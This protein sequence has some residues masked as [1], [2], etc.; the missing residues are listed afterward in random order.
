MGER[1]EGF[2]WVR[3]DGADWFVAR[4]V[5]PVG[6]DPRTVLEPGDDRPWRESEVIE[7]GPYLGKEPGDDNR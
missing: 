7:W 4:V 6:D 2:W 5:E 3:V 1:A